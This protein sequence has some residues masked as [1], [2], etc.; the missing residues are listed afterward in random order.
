MLIVTAVSASVL[1]LWL[2]VLSANVI[3]LRRQLDVGLGDGG[4]DELY[5]AT[6]AQ[7]NL[8]E[9]APMGLLL[10]A[11]LELNQAPGWLSVAC[12]VCFVAGRLLH[13]I[14]IRRAES[15]WQCR[16]FGMVLT[17][18]ALIAMAVA[19]LAVVLLAKS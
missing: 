5:R 10:L 16:V 9:Y 3:R 15:P 13:P 6:R 14:G 12:A 2:V 17:L 19:L 1:G 8:V 11:C 7:A 4:H 18:T